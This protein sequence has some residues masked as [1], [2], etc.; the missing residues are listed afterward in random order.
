M[1]QALASALHDQSCV[2]V[3]HSPHALRISHACTMNNGPWQDTGTASELLFV[4]LQQLQPT[5]SMPD[6]DTLGVWHLAQ[7]LL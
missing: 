3:M 4:H 5:I 2:L 7:S 1:L 6:R